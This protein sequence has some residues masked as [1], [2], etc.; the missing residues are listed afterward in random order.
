M[1]SKIF[2]LAV[3]TTAL[4]NNNFSNTVNY[5]LIT[6]NTIDYSKITPFLSK[7]NEGTLVIYDM[8]ETLDETYSIISGSNKPEC[9][10]NISYINGTNIIVYSIDTKITKFLKIEKKHFC[11]KEMIECG[12]LTLVLKLINLIDSGIL[13]AMENNIND[14]WINLEIIDFDEMFNLYKN[15]LTNIE[16][17]TNITLAKQKANVILTQEKYRLNKILTKTYFTKF[18]NKIEVW[19]GE[20]I[21]DIFS[22]TADTIG[23]FFG[24][25]LDKTLLDISVE[26]KIIIVLVLFIYLRK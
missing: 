23:S 15:S 11:K 26:F 24:T 19:I 2:H 14:L 9:K 1:I 4:S 6:H 7:I 13:L 25:I 20:P 18:T 12:E 5:P 21:K 17:L 10:Y 22:Y 3:L 16:L 8:C